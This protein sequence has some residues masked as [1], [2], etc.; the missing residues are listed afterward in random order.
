MVEKWCSQVRAVSSTSIWCSPAS[1][2]SSLQLILCWILQYL[3]MCQALWRVTV[4]KT[5]NLC[6]FQRRCWN[7]VSYEASAWTKQHSTPRLARHTD[8]QAL[9]PGFFNITAKSVRPWP[10][11]WGAIHNWSAPSP[12]I[13]PWSAGPTPWTRTLE[14]PTAGPS[15]SSFSSGFYPIV[16]VNLIA[17]LWHSYFCAASGDGSTALH[18][19]AASPLRRATFQIPSYS[20][21]EFWSFTSKRR[22][23]TLDHPRNQQSAQCCTAL[24]Q[25][26]WLVLRAKIGLH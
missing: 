21:S 26:H 2:D 4:W 1:Q 9:P 5:I 17:S 10:P 6:T 8:S 12:R 3:V 24:W 14:D 19:D 7:P 22:D 11:H 13:P 23:G 20:Q 18:A 25:A 15:L 16:V